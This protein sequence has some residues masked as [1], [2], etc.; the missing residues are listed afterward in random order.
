MKFATAVLFALPLVSGF[1]PS[2][3]F[4]AETAL[5]A[6]VTGPK[7]KAAASKEEDIAL[8]L[9]VIMDHDARST[10][11]SKEQFIQQVQAASKIEETI[12]EVDISIPYDAAAMLA[13][14]AS[15]KSKSFDDFKV[16]YL[17]DSVAHVI[18]KQPIDISIP[19]DA[20][21]KLAYEATDKSMP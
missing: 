4:G 17:A 3:R 7:G 19:Y 15:D 2:A 12:E 10:T 1:A 11:V 20:T 13:Y 9:Q 6:V 21:A 5:R 14:E 8:A 18:S 16:G